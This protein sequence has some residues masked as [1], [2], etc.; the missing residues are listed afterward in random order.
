MTTLSTLSERSVEKG[1]V[2]TQS[3]VCW[4]KEGTMA[5]GG[6]LSINGFYIKLKSLPK[7]TVQLERIDVQKHGRSGGNYTFIITL[8][9]PFHYYVATHES[10][11]FLH[12]HSPPSC[13]EGQV[14]VIVGSY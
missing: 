5:P 6:H 12:Q 10:R 2:S 4:P 8:F 3:G 1:D 7:I 13:Y 9:R 11:S 14:R